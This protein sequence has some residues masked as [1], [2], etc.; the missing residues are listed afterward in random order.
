MSNSDFCKDKKKP[1]FTPVK[2]LDVF[3]YDCIKGGQC[4][5]QTPAN[6]PVSLNLQFYVRAFFCIVFLV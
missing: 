6:S 4:T 3:L 2:S 5:T 1:G